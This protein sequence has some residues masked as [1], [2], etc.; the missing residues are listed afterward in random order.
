MNSLC[1]SVAIRD[2]FVGAGSST[3]ASRKFARKNPSRTN[4]VSYWLTLQPSVSVLS[5][6]GIAGYSGAASSVALMEPLQR[7]MCLSGP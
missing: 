2:H 1:R 6:A 7:S 3:A 5:V 4:S